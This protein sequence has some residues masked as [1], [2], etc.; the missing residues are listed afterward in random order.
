MLEFHTYLMYFTRLVSERVSD[1]FMLEF[2]HLHVGQEVLKITCSWSGKCL[3]QLKK[4]LT[5]K[6]SS[7]PSL[8]T[9]GKLCILDGGVLLAWKLSNNFLLLLTEKMPGYIQQQLVVSAGFV[10]LLFAGTGVVNCAVLPRFFSDVQL[11]IALF[12]S[13]QTLNGKTKSYC[14]LCT[15]YC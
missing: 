10:A 12:L 14:I 4:S 3:K 13:D 2:G 11:K 8:S 1:I 5:L 7:L 6:R 9:L 15:I